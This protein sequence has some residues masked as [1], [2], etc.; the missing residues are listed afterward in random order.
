MRRS[1]LG[2]DVAGKLILAF[3]VLMAVVLAFGI[4]MSVKQST[5]YANWCAERGGH[6]KFLRHGNMLCIG[7]DGR[8]IE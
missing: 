3:A 6:T 7:P 8:I 1:L 2:E 4:F 5:D